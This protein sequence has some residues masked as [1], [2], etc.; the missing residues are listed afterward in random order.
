MTF[1]KITIEKNHLISQDVLNHYR[2]EQ[3][4]NEDNFNTLMPRDM[5]AGT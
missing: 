2:G 5:E 1:S 3:V 4:K